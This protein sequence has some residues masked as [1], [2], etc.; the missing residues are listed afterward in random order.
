MRPFLERLLK[1][2]TYRI[3]ALCALHRDSAEWQT[4]VVY[5]KYNENMAMIEVIYIAS[6]VLMQSVS[7]RGSRG[8]WWEK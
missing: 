8:H 2:A 5:C 6:V 7:G 3:L 1:E 4:A